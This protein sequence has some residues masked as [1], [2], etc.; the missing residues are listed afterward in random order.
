[1]AS[2]SC[3]QSLDPLGALLGKSPIIDSLQ[4]KG[5]VREALCPLGKAEDMSSRDAVPPSVTS[6]L[7]PALCSGW[8][9]QPGD[10]TNERYNESER[11]LFMS[12]AK[13]RLALLFPSEGSCLD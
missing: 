5:I 10:F 12:T 13:P 6:L 4:R 2:Y 3:L 1:M 9:R 8:L 7:G 11:Q